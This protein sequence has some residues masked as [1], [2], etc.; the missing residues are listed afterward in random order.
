MTQNIERINAGQAIYNKPVLAIYDVLVL[1]ISHHFLW[2]CPTSKHLNLYNT[3]ISGNHLDIG[4][5][6]GFYLDKCKFPTNK[7]RL[8]LM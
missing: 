8:A 3:N 2:Q 7:P 4:V 1:G 6:S 5:G